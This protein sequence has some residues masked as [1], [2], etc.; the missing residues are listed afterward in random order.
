MA[1]D[2]NQS[3]MEVAAQVRSVLVARIGLERFELWLPPECQWVW[4]GAQLSL[5]LPSEFGCQIARRMLLKDISA[6]AIDVFGREVP[7][8]M[9]ADA[10]VAQLAASHAL[11]SKQ[12]QTIDSSFRLSRGT[13]ASSETLRN[14]AISSVEVSNSTELDEREVLS[15][16]GTTSLP[17]SKKPSS[18]AAPNARSRKSKSDNDSE[19]G[20]DAPITIQLNRNHESDAFD[21]KRDSVEAKSLDKDKKDETSWSDFIAG[22]SSQL[23]WT[24]V[25]LLA[26]D[27][28][29]MTPA[30][31]YGPHGVGKTHLANALAQRL[32]TQKRQ[33]RVLHITAEQFTNDFTEAYRG[34]GMPMLR[35]KYRD[36]DTLILDDLHFLIGK[37]AT[38]NELRH[39]LDN[40][41]K[42]NK[43]VLFLSDRSL[44][45]L[46]P[47]GSDFTGRLRSGLISPLLPLDE[48]T[49]FKMLKRDFAAAEVELS[50]DIIMQIASRAIGDG[51]VLKG[52]VKR[53]MAASYLHAGQLT[54]DIC[55]DAIN[56]LI[57][58]TQ[59]IVRLG[60]IARVVCEVF[61]LEP[62]S[63]Q[64]DRKTR[65]V[66]QPRMLAM[67]LAR[68][69]T[70]AAYQ[71]IGDF[72]G[73][74]RH[75]TVISAEKTVE[76]WLEENSKVNLA[77]GAVTIRDALRHVEASL[78]VG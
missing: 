65:V 60:D 26:N 66:S 77:R 48:S 37:K 41:T 1:Q 69:Y 8:T 54:W 21:S 71:E 16:T 57:Q 62:N 17:L 23:A 59:P 72:F 7:I 47:L 30:L 25:N 53:L 12:S 50:D 52:F 70:P 63:L 24:T 43:Q 20:Q 28:G 73:K 74:R 56:D 61:G 35:R 39:T 58:A 31:I 67:F 55:W 27:P 19:A 4:D 13:Q 22:E 32:R 11:Q 18:Y 45:E 49:R 46:E 64:S 14:D 40:L 44:A 38:I 10:N 9:Q 78:N 68:K 5:L 15:A 51:R 75:S 34:S 36:L 29:K 76:T 33:R 42:A 2:V 3:E 6:A